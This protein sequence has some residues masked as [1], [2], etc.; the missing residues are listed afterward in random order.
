LREVKPE[1][2]GED[3]N[4]EMTGD[5]HF[6]IFLVFIYFCA[7]GRNRAENLAHREAMLQMPIWMALIYTSMGS[8]SDRT[9]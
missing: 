5:Q 1:T 6:R 2:A 9:L 4:N 3:E 8:F 7:R